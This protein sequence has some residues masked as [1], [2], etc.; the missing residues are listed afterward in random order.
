MSKLIEARGLVKK[1]GDVMA[2]DG[3]DLGVDEGTVVGLLG[4]NGAG[5]TTVVS[6]L[7]TLLIPDSG[8][9][10][11]G[12]IDVLAS[13]KDVRRRIGLSGQF[14]AVDEYLTG[15]ENLDMIGRL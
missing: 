12:G 2:L 8:S 14:A 9:A 6:I 11:V 3:F 10:F 1:Y 5:K 7:S 4:P 13:P 15:F